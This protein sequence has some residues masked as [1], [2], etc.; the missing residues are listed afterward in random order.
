LA[1]IVAAL[2]LSFAPA[3][4]SQ[5]RGF[6]GEW[7]WAIY[8][9]DKSELPPAY[10]NMELKEVPAYALDLT[11]KQRGNRLSG[12]YG[13]LARYLARVDEG[14]FRTNIHGRSVRFTLKSNFGGSATVV[15]TLKGDTLLWRTIRSN[16]EAYFPKEVLLRRMK[17]GEKLPYVVYGDEVEEDESAVP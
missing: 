12:N 5:S 17:P 8:A 1:L 4:S 15:L 10:R 2:S 14:S 3:A 11:L 7:N 6:Q 16:G 13:L 9:Q